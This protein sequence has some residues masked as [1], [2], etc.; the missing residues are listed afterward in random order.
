MVVITSRDGKGGHHTTG[1][2]SPYKPRTWQVGDCL[3]SC[4]IC[5]NAQGVIWQIAGN[6]ASRACDPLLQS[7]LGSPFKRGVQANE[8]LKSEEHQRDCT[9]H[10]PMRPN[11]Q[12]TLA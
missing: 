7:R 12:S 3:Q 8:E 4:R 9:H 11:V 2:S 1:A 10:V 6:V 5:H